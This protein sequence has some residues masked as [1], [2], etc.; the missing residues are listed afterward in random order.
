[1]SSQ[2]LNANLLYNDGALESYDC[3]EGTV[4]HDYH[5]SHTEFGDIGY[6]HNPDPT[7]KRKKAYSVTT[8]SIHS[9]GVLVVHIVDRD[10]HNVHEHYL[11]E[12]N[13]SLD[14]NDKQFSYKVQIDEG[15][16]NVAWIIPC[17]KGTVSMEEMDD[18][19][20]SGTNYSCNVVNIGG[21][22]S[23]GDYPFHESVSTTHSNSYIN[24]LDIAVSNSNTFT[25]EKGDYARG[26]TKL[27]A[28]TTEGSLTLTDVN[29][30]ALRDNIGTVLMGSKFSMTGGKS[31]VFSGN[32]LHVFEQSEVS[33]TN[34]PKIEFKDNKDSIFYT[35]PSYTS[36]PYSTSM[37]FTNCREIVF[38]DNTAEDG[39]IVGRSSDSG[40]DEFMLF[41]NCDTVTVERNHATK[42]RLFVIHQPKFKGCT[43][44]TLSNNQADHG[45]VFG[46]Q[47][48]FEEIKGSIKINDNI[49]AAAGERGDGT[50]G[51]LVTG[52]YRG[53]I[54][55][56][57]VAG[58]TATMEI[59]GNSGTGNFRSMVNER[60]EASTLASL[61]I[62]NNALKSSTTV[63]AGR[64]LSLL[65][66][67]NIKTISIKGN[68]V[69]F[70]DS[71]GGTEN[72]KGGFYRSALTGE[73]V[74][75]TTI[76]NFDMLEIADNVLG[77]AIGEEGVV[78]TST[79]TAKKAEALLTQATISGKTDGSL[80]STVKI[81]GNKLASTTEGEDSV[82]S[83]YHLK[84]NNLAEFDLIENKTENIHMLFGNID[85]NDVRDLVVRGNEMR[86]DETG[87]HTMH[88]VA[89]VQ[90]W[91]QAAGSTKLLFENNS[92]VNGGS[93]SVCGA[94][95]ILYKD[96]DF[97]FDSATITFSGNKA[98]GNAGVKGAGIYVQYGRNGE[99]N[100]SRQLHQHSEQ[101]H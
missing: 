42:K 23:G 27:G 94:A 5:A 86:L 48:N 8:K 80:T 84:L 21:T 1:M 43:N 36:A 34:V 7:G 75:D 69:G 97:A 62:C 59:N 11:T 51:Y 55:A 73:S 66:L 2:T 40:S 52:N 33:L 19:L 16:G 38:S 9:F 57:G 82:S 10:Q 41:E 63:Y 71:S 53:E 3:P 92:V 32:L 39:V 37:T 72:I 61:S 58:Q 20:I 79:I 12:V 83:T 76:R 88:A 54:I 30:V 74:S 4:W 31:A 26:G 14:G 67:D 77:Y 96:S 64:V 56:S 18:I 89:R 22:W 81:T 15:E 68:I 101:R 93:A 49:S 95:L 50:F 98:V 47:L 13:F 87:R 70:M 28:L 17:E 45:E 46:R 91:V 90:N 65:T 78:D 24:C 6:D 44:V 60:I 85:A 100:L 99:R 25:F 35:N 29:Q